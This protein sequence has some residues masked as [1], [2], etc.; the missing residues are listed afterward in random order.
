MQCMC[1]G[2]AKTSSAERRPLKAELSFYVCRECQ[3]VSC[4]VL[5]IEGIEIAIDAGP[6]GSDRIAFN[7][8]TV[9]SA[10]Q[11]YADAITPQSSTTTTGEQA[12]FDF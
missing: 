1:G 4:G 8:L 6:T 5:Y 3:L 10:R 7:S 2:D 11:L 12:T 9:E